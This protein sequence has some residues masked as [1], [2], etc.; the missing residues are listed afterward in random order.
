MVKRNR[1]YFRA[2][3]I[4]NIWMA[5]PLLF[6]A[7]SSQQA[8][9]LAFGM[10]LLHYY[11]A[12]VL[13]AFNIICTIIWIIKKKISKIWIIVSIITVSMNIIYIIKLMPYMPLSIS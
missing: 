1:N 11:V 13:C 9:Y 7:T 6:Y 3:I 12:F 4:I 2:L 8:S 5:Y 10:M